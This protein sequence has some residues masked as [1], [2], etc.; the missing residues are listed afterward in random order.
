MK[1]RSDRYMPKYGMHG[2]SHLK[3]NIALIIIYFIL[4]LIIEND[5]YI[6]EEELTYAEHP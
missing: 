6:I 2:G 3:G 5:K 4:C 1:D